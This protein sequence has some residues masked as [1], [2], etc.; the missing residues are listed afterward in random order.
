MLA[1]AIKTALISIGAGFLVEISVAWINSDFLKSFFEEDLITILIALLAINATTMGIVLTKIKEMIEKQK[2]GYK[3]FS[4]TREQMLL[5][6]KE[7]IS[8]IALATAFLTLNSSE[9]ISDIKN[10]E[11][12]I[13]SLLNG[14][15]IYSLIILYDT[16][17]SVLII[18]DYKHN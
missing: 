15:F 3:I 11:L 13:N 9:A 4:N 18:I 8:L 7:Q 6:I 17:K 5:S 1:Q 2:E 12:T 10:A 14:I 16:A